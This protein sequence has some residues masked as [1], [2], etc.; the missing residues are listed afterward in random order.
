MA[1]NLIV[2][3]PPGAG[4]G[5][6]AERFARSRGIPKISTGDML[7]EAARIGTEVGLR[8]RQTMDRGDLVGDDV[9]IGI[10]RERLARPDVCDGFVLDGFPRTVGQAE[11]LDRLMEGRDP[12][13]VVDIKVPDAE[14]IRRLASR[15]IC[16][17]CGSNAD[18][19][20]GAAA[21]AAQVVVER[22]GRCG[23]SLTHRADD[24]E[25]VVRERLK[26]YRRDTQ[27]L[28]DYYRA[29]QTFRSIDGARSPIEVGLE[30]AAAI[31]AAGNGLAHGRPGGGVGR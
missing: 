7:R 10:V 30:L 19:I 14:L 13:L 23:G 29:R 17:D 16:G 28:V 3:G 26:V 27:P 6:Q 20:E 2:L 1:F 9:M 25:N 5:T 8:A 24:N 4:K 12:L 11:S 31:V 15:R 18:S 21:P 22:C